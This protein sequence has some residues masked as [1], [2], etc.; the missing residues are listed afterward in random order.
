MQLLNTY[1]LTFR[2]IFFVVVPALVV[3]ALGYKRYLTDPLPHASAVR[4]VKGVR[5]PVE[6]SRDEHGV[7]HIR[8]SDYQDVYFAMGYAHAQDRLWQLEVQRRMSRGTMSALFGRSYVDQ[9]IWI[10]TLG[11]RE[12]AA[13]AL[14]HLS[15]EAVASL[16]AYAA[17]INAWLKEGQQLPVEFSLLG[18]RPEPWTAEDSLAWVKMFALNLAGNLPSELRNYVASQ[19]LSRAQFEFLFPQ[20]GSLASTDVAAPG[21]GAN[22]A[23]TQRTLAGLMNVQEM[24]ATDAKLGG[25]FVG[26]NAWVISGTLTGGAGA[27]LANDPHVGLQI[28]S[29]WYAVT[30]NAK[31]LE[32]S[33]MSL[34]GVPLVVFGRNKHIAWG[35]TSMLADVQ[36]VYIEQ[37]MPSD[38]RF[39]RVGNEWRQFET[40]D[41][42]LQVRADPLVSLRNDLKPI[43][44][45][46]RRSLHG[47]IISDVAD[48]RSVPMALQWVGLD[49]A[50]T[51]YESF[52]RLNRASDWT[53]F[54][55]A[56]RL[57]VAPA[58]NMLYA[59]VDGNIGFVG[60]G[61]VPVRQTGS[62]AFPVDGADQAN[63]WSGY[64]PFDE[65]P[66]SF[67][68]ASGYWINANN[69][70]SGNEYPHLISRD[71]AQPARHDRIEQMLT[72]R[73]AGNAALSVDDMKAIQADVVDRSVTQLL[74]RLSA[75]KGATPKQRQAV[76]YLQGWDARADARSV[77]ATIF[78]GWLR[79]LKRHLFEDE[80]AGFW[81]RTSDRNRLDAA[82]ASV[83][84][85]ISANALSADSMWCDKVSTTVAEECEQI[86]LE[87]LQEMLEETS[88]LLGGDIADWHWSRAQATLYSH[89]PF[90]NHRAFDRL[91]ERRVAN[92]GSPNTINVA[93]SAFDES[94]GYV[95]AFGAGFRQ[96]MQ[97][98]RDGGDH[99][100]MNSTGQSGQVVSSHYDDMVKP[101]QDVAYFPMKG[102]KPGQSRIELRPHAKP[103]P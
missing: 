31:D 63:R 92:G 37:A 1:P 80:M 76:A 18:A 85:D 81:N 96:I 89:L 51:T 49:S 50:D 52:F 19:Y 91:F 61:R 71:W 47:P 8:A 68:P 38:S 23:A 69:R 94:H 56:L 66:Q 53:T 79:H 24:L 5:G 70:N 67:N 3:L 73:L 88:K 14:P 65:M 100:F 55:S 22:S 75:V 4:Y 83:S 46:T 45:Q 44:F 27:I 12:S 15:Q 34:V 54:R 30:Q 74:A 101:F 17:G 7:A 36:D 29:M 59:D 78:Y 57:H 32:V 99:W 90:S 6:I 21:A 95:Q 103:A 35:G 28:P 58:L 62:G 25:P 42:V 43:R 82:I 39:Y 77:G 72:E 11:I 93:S 60:A 84:A 87:S 41:E 86:L 16:D 48:G 9:D 2:A 13:A 20:A 64:I 97:M 33:G 10:R 102:S 40:R 26:S 98:R